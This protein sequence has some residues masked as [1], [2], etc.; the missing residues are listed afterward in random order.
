M[1]SLEVLTMRSMAW[2]RAKGE[3]FAMLATYQPAHGSLGAGGPEQSA[4]QADD[5]GERIRQFV[6]DVEE[7]FRST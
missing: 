7:R 5:M 6:L 3:L 1:A 2:E 4:A